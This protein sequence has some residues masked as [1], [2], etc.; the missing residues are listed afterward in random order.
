[1]R[2]TDDRVEDEDRLAA[3]TLV[4]RAATALAARARAER[5]GV[6][7]LSQVSVLGWL[8]RVGDLTPGEVAARLRMLPQ[9][10]TRTLR[11]LEQNGWVTRMRDPSDGRQ[12]VLMITDAG[13]ETL[14]SEMRPRYEWVA[15]GMAQ[16]MTVTEGKLLV[17]A[18][19]LLERLAAV[20]AS[21][22]PQEAAEP[23]SEAVDR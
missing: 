19:E 7:T 6:L 5:A 4:G 14:T 9:S 3:A 11:S 22:I 21:P 17:L 12:S 20:D 10:L 18:A 13:R 23:R 8:V 2:M 1:M 16:T 15:S